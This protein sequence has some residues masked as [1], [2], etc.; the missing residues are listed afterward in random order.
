MQCRPNPTMLIALVLLLLAPA[1]HAAA[2]EANARPPLMR[3]FVGINA[4]TVQFPPT[5]Y[6]PLCG[7]VRDY[8]AI[9]WDTGDHTAG[10]TDFPRAIKHITWADDSGNFES[11]DGVPNWADLYGEWNDAGFEVNA[12]LMLPT[13]WSDPAADAQRY[14][15]AFAKSLGPNGTTPRVTSVEIGNEPAGENRIPDELYLTLFT[16]MAKGLRAGDADLLIAT[17]A[18]APPEP[19]GW[20]KSLELFIPHAELFDVV[21]IHRYAFAE[22]WPTWRR[23]HPEDSANGF[24]AFVRETLAYRDEHLPGKQVWLT[25]FGYDAATGTPDPDGPMA[26]FIDTDDLQQA[27]WIVRS[28]LC[29]ATTDLDRAYLYWFNDSDAPSFHAASGV[30]R[31]YEPKPSYHA[32]RQMQRILGEY[33]FSKTI[34][35]SDG[36]RVIL[37]FVHGGDESKF[38]WAVWS[39]TGDGRKSSIDCELPGRLLAVEWMATTEQVQRRDISHHDVRP[40]VDLAIDESV[41]YFIMER[42]E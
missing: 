14:G 38:A 6:A 2:P 7:L 32:M 31:N 20:S 8:H 1:L 15:R 42:F 37:E 25:E 13:R 34:E 41:L 33:R 4:H 10:A 16:H 36:E 5:L 27:Q 3:D 30:T 26:Q 35:W 12:S 40:N 11:F 19:D 29:L 23:T 21:N 28:F 24:L 17:C 22:G 18:A 9:D 39:P